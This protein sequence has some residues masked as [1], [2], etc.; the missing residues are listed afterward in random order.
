M[1][2]LVGKEPRTEEDIQQDPYS[3]HK[4]FAE[5]HI[6]SE[7]L[8]QKF[9]GKLSRFRGAYQIRHHVRALNECASSNACA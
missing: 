3:Y 8:A 5:L 2:M 6:F 7:G 1:K 9:N 4:K